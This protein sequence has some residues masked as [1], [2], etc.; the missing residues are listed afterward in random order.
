[1]K[2]LR[3]IIGETECIYQATDSLHVTEKGYKSAVDNRLISQSEIGKL[4]VERVISEGIYYGLNRYDRDGVR[5]DSGL[6]P[7]ATMDASGL[8]C[9]DQFSRLREITNR[10]PDGTV[11]VNRVKKREA[12]HD[13][14]G[15][16]RSDGTVM[17]FTL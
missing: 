14:G 15:V 10:R 13:V 12:K 6:K 1:M 17:P 16:A 2:S 3:Q 8:W 11:V 5:V 4:K 9:E 7:G